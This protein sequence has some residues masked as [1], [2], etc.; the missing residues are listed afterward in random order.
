ME[1]IQVLLVFLACSIVVCTREFNSLEHVRSFVPHNEQTTAVQDLLKR[2]VGERNEEIKI[3]IL[4]EPYD[5]DYAFLQ[6]SNNILH[7]TG[8]SAVAIAYGFN[9]YLKYFC[10]KQMSWTGDQMGDLPKPL[11]A[12]PSEGIFIQAGVKYRYYQ[13]VCSVSYTSV[14]WNWTRWEREIDWMALNGINLPLAFTG[15]EAIWQR[16]YLKLGLT[17]TDLDAHF[18][19]PA[20]LAWGRMGNIRGWGGPLPDSWKESQLTLQ[21]KILQRMRSLGMIPVLPGFAGHV[22]L[23]LGNLYPNASISRLGSWVGFSCNLSCSSLLEPDDP[24]YNAIGKMFIEEQIKEYNGS[25]HIYSADSF[26]EM[27]PR[28]NDTTYLA[29]AGHAVYEAMKAADP[30]AIW[31]MQNWLFHNAPGFWKTPQIKALL[32]SVPQGKMLVLELFSEGFPIYKRTHFYYGQPFIWCMMQNSGGVLGYFGRLEVINTQPQEA[33]TDV[34]STMVGIGIVPEGNNQNYLVFDLMLE[35]GYTVQPTNLTYWLK[36]FTLRRY[37]CDNE[38]AVA[39]WNLLGTGIYN[40]SEE[41]VS[42]EKVLRT[43]PISFRP[44]TTKNSLP[45]WYNYSRIENA[46]DR[47]MK[48]LDHLPQS[49]TVA[50]DT[51]DITREMMQEIHRILLYAMLE[52]FENKRYLPFLTLSDY[53]IELVDDFDRI[54]STDSHFMMGCWIKDAKALATTMQEKQLYEFNA[55]IQVTLWGPNGE[56]LDYANKHWGSLVKHFYKPRWTLFVELLKES[57]INGTDFDENKFRSTVLSTVEKPFTKA[58]D[59]YPC[60]PQEEPYKVAREMYQKWREFLTVVNEESH[61]LNHSQINLPGVRV[62]SKFGKLNAK[63]SRQAKS[64]SSLGGF[65]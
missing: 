4:P 3:E 40:F 26:N 22:P 17:K 2:V 24:L 49:S 55:R 51:V 25:N 8:S 54:L 1:H 7:I 63:V 10:R 11:P 60:S 5:Q 14:W 31:L 28:S 18:A 20:F 6:M 38:D 41:N 32:T 9:H 36:E 53:L 58:E 42:P 43:G 47:F 15:Q 50:Y 37:G 57:L 62:S 29:N 21:H 65:S 56:I 39:T 48:S 34:N 19:G 12:V 59:I 64:R 45:N 16:V 27:I 33:L 44:T 30:Q 52:E 35:A 61:E 13:N 46:W 23:A